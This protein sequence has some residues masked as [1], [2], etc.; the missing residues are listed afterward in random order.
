MPKA[1]YHSMYLGTWAAL[2]FSMKA[3]SMA[4]LRAAMMMMPTLRAMPSGVGEFRKVSSAP[5]SDMIHARAYIKKM[6]IVAAATIMTNRLVT[7]M[8]RVTY[9][10]SIVAKI[11]SVANTAW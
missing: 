6:P 8:M 9:R 1:A 4:R 3:K 5:N 7:L 11:A 2:A 10:N